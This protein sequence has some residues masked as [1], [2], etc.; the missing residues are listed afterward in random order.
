MFTLFLVLHWATPQFDTSGDADLDTNEDGLSVSRWQPS[1][2]PAALPRSLPRG[3]IVE[4]RLPKA[5]QVI[6]PADG[7]TC[8]LPVQQR[9]R[10]STGFATTCDEHPRRLQLAFLRNYYSRGPPDRLA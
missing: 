9:Q 10:P 2:L 6:L 8:L 4:L 1:S 7:Q 3:V 5:E